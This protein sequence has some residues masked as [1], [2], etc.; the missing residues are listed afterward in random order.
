MPVYDFKKMVWS[1][2]RQFR[3]AKIRTQLKEKNKTK[4]SWDFQNEE[5]EGQI[6]YIRSCI[7][8]LYVYKKKKKKDDPCFLNSLL[9]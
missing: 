8:T 6:K 9:F 7:H 5:L 2:F 4:P 1:E 3:E